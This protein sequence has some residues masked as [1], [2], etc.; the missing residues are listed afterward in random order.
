MS[1]DIVERGTIYRGQFIDGFH[2]I[3]WDLSFQL[4]CKVKTYF[5]QVIVPVTIGLT[6]RIYPLTIGCQILD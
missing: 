6:K 4:F 5:V 1:R 2:D 3:F